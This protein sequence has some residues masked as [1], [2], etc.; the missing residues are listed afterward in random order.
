MAG[1]H[2][3]AEPCGRA[4]SAA[5]FRFGPVSRG[6]QIDYH[7]RSA[8]RRDAFVTTLLLTVLVVL[9]VVVLAPT[10]YFVWRTQ[11]IARRAERLVPPRGQFLEVDGNRLHYVEEGQGR[12]ILFIHGFGGT[13]HHF[14][15]PLF[16]G[17]IPGYRLIALDRPGAGYSTRAAG[18]SASLPAQAATIAAFIDRMKLDRPLV[19]GHSL[20]GM[21]TLTL[22]LNHPDRISGIVL[23]SP[24]TKPREGVAP[25][26]APLYIVSPLKRW[27]IANTVAIP[28][29][30]KAAPQTL[31]YVFGP[32]ATPEGY[33]TEGGGELGLR[34]R[35]FQNMVADLVAVGDDMPALAARYGELAMPAGLIFG[36]ADMVLD[37]REHGEAFRD[38][39]SGLDFELVEGIGHHPQYWA[40]ERVVAMIRRVAERAFGA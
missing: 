40:R 38:R 3:P 35:H 20:G 22:A 24:L 25:E 31:A 4:A 5:R 14:R 19:V 33:M 32:Q 29:A 11:A 21:I 39:V 9:A 2:G 37:H 12:T 1:R 15:H 23:V 26:M 7:F 10:A 17:R 30:L 27:L 28:A 13:L 34:P 18:A 16:G 6:H 8:A 36:S